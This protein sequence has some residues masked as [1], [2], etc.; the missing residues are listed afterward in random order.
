M[1]KPAP[2]PRG[3]SWNRIGF[4]LSILAASAAFAQAPAAR[5]TFD[6]ASVKANT[7][8][9]GMIM[10]GPPTGG[11]FRATNATL[12]MLVGLAYKMQN[13]AISGGPNWIDSDHYD[14]EAK[15]SDGNLTFDEMRPML[16]ALLEERFQLKVHTEKKDVPVYALLPGKNGA[17]L[18]AA[19]EGGCVK[20]DPKNPTLPPPPPPGAGRGAGGPVML[21]P[22]PCGGMMMG[23]FQMQGGNISMTQFVGGLSNLLGR[24][25]IDKTGFTGTFDLHLEYSPEGLAMGRGGMPMPPPPPGAVPDTSNTTVFTAIQ[26]QLGL[27]LESQKAPDDT[28]VIDHAEKATEN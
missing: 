27:R 13:F 15:A 18:P 7:S 23:P 28:L 9:S 5:P 14:I 1:S 16:Q 26:E 10:I 20:L 4:V 3:R 19:K 11:R 6:V 8:G 21:G 12:K 25:V 22:P 24:P 2:P 17:K